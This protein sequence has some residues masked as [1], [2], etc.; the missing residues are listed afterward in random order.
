MAKFVFALETLKKYR[1]KKLLT[2]RKDLASIEAE[3]I[4]IRGARDLA[5]QGLKE[6]IEASRPRA[7]K[8][9]MAQLSLH[10]FLSEGQ[11]A[12]IQ[13]CESEIRRIE[14]DAERHR[15]WVAHLGKELKAVEKLEDRKRRSW[16]EL[17]KKAERRKADGWVAERWTRSG[18]AA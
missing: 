5:I 1:E 11:H 13:S 8:G 14:A 9:T 12:L 3:L 2:A 6:S 15:S 16:E 7:G 4:K 17:E 18:G 10:S